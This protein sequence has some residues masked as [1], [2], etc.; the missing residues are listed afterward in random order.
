MYAVSNGAIEKT[1]NHKSMQHKNNIKMCHFT[2][3][4][5]DSGM[6]L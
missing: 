1:M 6:R 3:M 4:P 2:E 5:S